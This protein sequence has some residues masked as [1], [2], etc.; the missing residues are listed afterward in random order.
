M[1]RQ[2]LGD[3][4]DSF[5][6]DYHHFLVEALGYRQLQVVWMMTPDDHGPDGRTPPE[7]FPANPEVLKFCNKLK[8]KRDPGMLLDLPA[9][10]TA[11]YKVILYKTDE[12]LAKTNRGAYFSDLAHGPDQVI[13]LDPDNGFEPERSFN[14]KHVRYAEVEGILQKVSPA[15]IITVF[16]HHR[17]M[18]FPDDLARIRQRLYSGYSTAIHWHS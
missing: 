14:E 12:S 11:S 6:W 2:Y 8:K 4:K 17:R 16:Q 13:F 9:T 18:S 7:L 1:K 15:S 10:T 5:K 3:S